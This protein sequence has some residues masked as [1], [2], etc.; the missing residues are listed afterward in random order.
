MAL[1]SLRPPT[2]GGEFKVLVIPAE[3]PESYYYN[4]EFHLYL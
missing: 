3:V 1:L 2:T 4:S